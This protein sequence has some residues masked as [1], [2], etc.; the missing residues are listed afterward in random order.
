MTDKNEYAWCVPCG[1]LVVVLLIWWL[2]PAQKSGC[3]C[4]HQPVQL[5]KTSEESE[6]PK[7]NPA[8][9][10]QNTEDRDNIRK[11]IFQSN[12]ASF[13]SGTSRLSKE[14]EDTLGRVG[15]KVSPQLAPYLKTTII[16]F[17]VFDDTILKRPQPS[18]I[19]GVTLDAAV[20]GRV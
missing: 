4:Q 2:M 17:D 13:G 19:P 20:D 3:G 10:Y 6:E 5:T 9:I 12:L 8:H 14:V 18:V 16:D 7:N 15:A 1:L 11:N